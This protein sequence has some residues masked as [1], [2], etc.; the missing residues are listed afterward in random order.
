MFSEEFDHPDAYR[1][2]LKKLKAMKHRTGPLSTY[3]IRFNALAD[4]S[5]LEP[6]AIAD[7]FRESLQQKT[8]M[9]IV[10]QGE[11]RRHPTMTLADLHAYQKFC[12]QVDIQLFEAKGLTGSKGDSNPTE[13]S[14][15]PMDLDASDFRGPVSPEEKERRKREKLCPYDG[16]GDC[17]G[18][19]DANN[20]TNLKNRK[21]GFQGRRA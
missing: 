17:G 5:G 15:T 3:I 12:R 10:S 19:P 16:K 1:R 18:Y 14:H 4:L 11:P 6:Y 13:S 9:Q 8:L 2:N 20:C 7:I 21:S